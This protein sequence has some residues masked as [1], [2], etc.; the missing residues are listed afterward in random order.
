MHAVYGQLLMNI[1]AEPTAVFQRRVG[2][3]GWQKLRIVARVLLPRRGGA[4][5]G[6]C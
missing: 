3:S 4:C 2:L 5:H 1:A 6:R